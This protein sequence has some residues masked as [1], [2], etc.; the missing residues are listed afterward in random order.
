MNE[1][2]CR[3]VTEAQRLFFPP[4]TKFENFS[5]VYTRRNAQ[6]NCSW[7]VTNLTNPTSPDIS[8]TVNINDCNAAV[9]QFQG[10]LN[11]QALTLVSNH[12]I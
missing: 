7:L 10:T 9:S 5:V 11:Y 4:G 2:I 3:N 12:I 1:S 6:G 8:A